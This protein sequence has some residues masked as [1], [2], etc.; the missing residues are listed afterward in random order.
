MENE[1]K[2]LR[3]QGLLAEARR[4]LGEAGDLADQTSETIHFMGLVFEPSFGWF[5]PDGGLQ[6]ASDWNS[7]DCV[8]GSMYAEGYGMEGWKHAPRADNL[9]AFDNRDRFCDKCWGEK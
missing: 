3:M 4:L 7:S 5:S 6:Q 8:I 1:S 9:D 2:I